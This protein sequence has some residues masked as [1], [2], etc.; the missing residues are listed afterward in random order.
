MRFSGIGILALG[1]GVLW[2]SSVQAQQV[3]F[4][5]ADR[6]RID[7]RFDQLEKQ[8]VRMETTLQMFME[9]TNQ[10]FEQVDQRFAEQREDI[11]QRFAEMMSFL[12]IITGIFTVIMAAAIGFAFWDR[13][14]T[15][16][17]AKE[18]TLEALAKAEESRKNALV[19]QVVAEVFRRLESRKE[20]PPQSVSLPATS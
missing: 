13:H 7:Q 4:T 1:L 6:E 17:K 20:P 11:N 14:T 12:Q 15:V 3:G 10:R 5:Q 2:V 18:V 19:E 9:S 16:S 8:M